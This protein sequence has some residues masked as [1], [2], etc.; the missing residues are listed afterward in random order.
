MEAYERSHADRPEVLAKLR[1]MRTTE[2]L[3]GYDTLSPEAIAVALADADSET[4]KNVRDYER[5]FRRRPEVMDE[6]A[7]VLPTAA[8]SAREVRD[9]EAKATLLREG[10]EGRARPSEACPAASPLDRDASGFDSQ[11]A[12]VGHPPV[13]AVGEP[14][15]AANAAA[16]TRPPGSSRSIG[17]SAAPPER[18]SPAG[19][20]RC[21]EAIRSAG[22]R[23]ASRLSAS[24]SCSATGSSRRGGPGA[25]GP[26]A[27][28]CRSRTPRRRGRSSGRARLGGL[29]IAAADW[30]ARARHL[31]PISRSIAG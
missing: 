9:R 4:V 1:Y 8:P 2:P 30:S 6:T 15:E 17:A 22:E 5:K 29:A 3:A 18:R 27:P 25:A 16:G 20:T 13:S 26:R 19:D 23:S 28:A 12:V 10:F 11:R 7:R 21:Q 31:R 24:A 14:R